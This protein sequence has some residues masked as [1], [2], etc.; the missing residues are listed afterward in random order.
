MN[1]RLSIIFPIFNEEKRID[2]TFDQIKKFSSENEKFDL[3]FLFV[4]DGSNDKSEIKIKNFIKLNDNL[5][6]KY[7][8]SSKNMGKGNALKLGVEQASMDWILTTDVD[9]SVPLEQVDNWFK[10]FKL[11]NSSKIVFFG[12]R[13][14]DES[15]VEKKFYR[16][17]LGI[18]FSF[19]IK[20]LFNINIKDSQCGFKLYTKKIAKEIFSKLETLGFA[21]DIELIQKLNNKKIDI[22]ELPVTWKHISQ[23][24]LNIFTDSIRMIIDILRIYRKFK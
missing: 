12:S 2:N 20:I 1:L 4:N 18:I 24:K 11:E 16:Y 19:L 6:S 13:N 22:K 5:N 10:N 8:K 9:L 17:I 23:S 15:I 14:L 7:I 3:E 21:H